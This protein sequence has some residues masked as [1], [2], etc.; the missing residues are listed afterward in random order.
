MSAI[1]EELH[2]HHGD[3][4]AEQKL[5][6]IRTEMVQ[7]VLMVQSA[8]EL[9]KQIE[10]DLGQ[11]LPETVTPEEFKHVVTWLNE[12][13]VD[14]KEILGAIEADCADPAPHHTT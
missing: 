4:C 5:K 1:Y 11:N 7:P 3:S 8:V 6:V 10:T 9:L 13:A 12:A 14:L 2:K